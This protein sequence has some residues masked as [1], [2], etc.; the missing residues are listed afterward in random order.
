MENDIHL[1]TIQIIF[2]NGKFE[3][4]MTNTENYIII[5]LNTDDLIV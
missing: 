1:L 2:Q 3:A 4:L 5:L